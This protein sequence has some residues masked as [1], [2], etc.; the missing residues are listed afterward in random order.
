MQRAITVLTDLLAEKGH[1]YADIRYETSDVPPNSKLITFLIN[2]GPKVKVKKIDFHGNTV[3]SDRELRK[4]MKFIKQ[5][6]LISTFTG[7]ATFDRNKL[8][9]QL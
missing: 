4:S 2:E 6:G 5:T 8:E 7:K 9:Q 1:Q 3:F